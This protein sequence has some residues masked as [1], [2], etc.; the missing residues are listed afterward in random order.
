MKFIDAVRSTPN[1]ALCLW[2]TIISNATENKE[3]F[4]FTSHMGKTTE[5]S[6]FQFLS[7][8]NKQFISN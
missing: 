6:P 1:F 4:T 7:K 3:R 5:L 2:L 8:W